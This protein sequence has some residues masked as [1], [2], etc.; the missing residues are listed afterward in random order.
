[1]FYVS[2]I[3]S[4]SQ[5]LVVGKRDKRLSPGLVGRYGTL[6]GTSERAISI[7]CVITSI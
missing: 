6:S 5:T 4:I 7:V 3:D 1:M 2:L